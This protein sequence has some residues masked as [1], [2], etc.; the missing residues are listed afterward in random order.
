MASHA[1]P[2]IPVLETTKGRDQFSKN[3]R[4]I[5]AMLQDMAGSG[6][7]HEG[8]PN[9]ERGQAV[10]AHGL[11]LCSAQVPQRA[12]VSRTQ[13]GLSGAHVDHPQQVIT[14]HT[15][16]LIRLCDSG[17]PG[18][19]GRDRAPACNH[20]RRATNSAPSGAGSARGGAGGLDSSELPGRDWGNLDQ[21]GI[22][23]AR[24]PGFGGGQRQ[25]GE[26][27]IGAHSSVERTGRPGS[28]GLSRRQAQQWESQRARA[29]ARAA[30]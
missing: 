27:Q 22:N 8:A 6:G 29:G 16:M 5:Q 20:M 28:R 23:G 25:P 12:V 26:E 2:F 4:K 10:A 11:S 15:N 19:N 7:R 18:A 30:A 24:Q 17:L 1:T 13:R 14:P 3:R 21:Y 9:A